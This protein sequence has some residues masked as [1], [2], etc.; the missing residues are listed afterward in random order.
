VINTE[1]L[2]QEAVEINRRLDN[3]YL[4][5]EQHRKMIMELLKK[6]ED[7]NEVKELVE[8]LNLTQPGKR[9]E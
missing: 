8:I 1:V 9:G 2:K 4:L 7:N 6:S 3:N 5:K